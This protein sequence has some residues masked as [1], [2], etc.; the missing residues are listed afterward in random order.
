M[1]A[2]YLFRLK[3]QG[4]LER[5]PQ[6]T[7]YDDS[8]NLLGE[9]TSYT[10]RGT[11][12]DVQAQHFRGFMAFDSPL[13]RYL[14]HDPP[15]PLRS[16]ELDPEAQGCACPWCEE[17]RGA[18]H[19]TGDSDGHRFCYACELAGCSEDTARC[20]GGDDGALWL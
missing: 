6:A 2:V 11:A 19:G 5:Y 7:I 17:E 4:T 8:F 9:A 18:G 15:A 1:T 12:W 10:F 14:P 16:E 13:L 3:N 20:G